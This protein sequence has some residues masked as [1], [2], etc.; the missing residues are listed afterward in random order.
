MILVQRI[1][2]WWISSFN[3]W[4]MAKRSLPIAHGIYCI[5]FTLCVHATS[6]INNNGGCPA[7]QIKL[8]QMR[9][10]NIYNDFLGRKS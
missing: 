7:A 10:E 4:G 9:K 3:C 8:Q 2:R 6:Q 1:G 5:G